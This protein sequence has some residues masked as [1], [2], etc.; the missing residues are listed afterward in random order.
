MFRFTKFRYL[1]IYKR[2]YVIHIVHK[3]CR[4]VMQ[5]FVS[6]IFNS[7]DDDVQKFNISI[8]QKNSENDFDYESSRYYKDV[9]SLQTSIVKR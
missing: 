3:V 2:L 8:E 4:F 5:S 6:D 7:D 9:G 1:K